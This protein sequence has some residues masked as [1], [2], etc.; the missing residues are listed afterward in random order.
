MSGKR[1]KKEKIWEHKEDEFI[2]NLINQ[3]EN[4]RWISIEK[5]FN[6]KF[7]AR[8]NYNSIRSR[9]LYNLSPNNRK[10]K[11]LNSEKHFILDYYI[12]N[13]S[14]WSRISNIIGRNDQIIKN[15]YYSNLRKIIRKQFKIVFSRHQKDMKI[16]ELRKESKNNFDKIYKEVLQRKLNFYEIN[17]DIIEEIC[18]NNNIISNNTPKKRK[19]SDDISSTYQKNQ[20]NK[21][22][23]KFPTDHNSSNDNDTNNIH[24]KDYS[25]EISFKN[26]IKQHN[27]IEKS[28]KNK[29]D[30][31]I[32]NEKIEHLNIDIKG[33]SM[34]TSN[35]YFDNEEENNVL[36]FNN[37]YEFNYNSSYN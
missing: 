8:R 14:K 22:F 4:I 11:L 15:F 27:Y 24:N 16:L 7:G 6:K 28:N 34:I 37:D 32:L 36:F 21:N 31:I 29:L 23:R 9:Y 17:E 19:E 13:G 12:N 20:S 1:Y 18:Y 2:A 3:S 35:N 26:K 10:G 25:Y 5:A 33:I 30:E